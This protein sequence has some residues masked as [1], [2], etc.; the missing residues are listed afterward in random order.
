M[1]QSPPGEGI[2]GIGVDVIEIAR[3]EKA[4]AEPGFAEYI[5]HPSES[6]AGVEPGPL[7]GRWAAKEAVAKAVGVHLAWHDVRIREDLRVE[8]ASAS[9][10]KNLT[11]HLSVSIAAD[12]ATAWAI[13][14]IR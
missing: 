13:A 7:A 12:L 2:Y 11:V 4:M 9:V 5:L 1:G 8:I 14:E 6:P 10:P 3:I